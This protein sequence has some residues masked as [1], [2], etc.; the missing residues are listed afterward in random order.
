MISND[1]L[2]NRTVIVT[3]A[4]R[5]LGRAIA[6]RFAEAGAAVALAARSTAEL[7][8]ATAAIRKNGGNAT[9]IATDVADPHQVD[10]L[11][12]TVRKEIGPVDIL[13]NNAGVIEP[14]DRFWNT[15]REQWRHLLEINVLGALHCMRL[16]LYDMRRREWGRI[17]NISSGAAE[18]SLPGTSL[19]SAS[20]AA[21]ERFAGTLAEE[22]GEGDVAVTTYRP[23]KVDTQMQVDIRN[24]D[25]ERF[26]Y[27]DAF[28][29]AYDRG[30]LWPPRQSAL[31][32]LWLATAPAAEIQGQVFHIDDP[33]LQQRIARDL[34]VEARR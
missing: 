9:A 7:D 34:G 18:K 33:A 10:H 23:G 6:E 32:A 17:I 15:R 5:G 16:A 21:L 25:S 22:L 30:E 1:M 20:K 8:E 2:Q 27:L 19:Y 13:V 14:I 26:P 3:G 28:R 31:G 29:E 11:F 24:T 4:G 12:A